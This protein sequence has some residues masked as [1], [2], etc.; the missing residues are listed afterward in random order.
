MFNSWLKKKVYLY[1]KKEGRSKGVSDPTGE[2]EKLL[3][4][5]QRMKHMQ[6]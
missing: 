3:K 6:L 2:N 1:D 4:I 5:Q